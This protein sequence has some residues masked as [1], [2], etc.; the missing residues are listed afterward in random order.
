MDIYAVATPRNWC[1]LIDG[2][3]Y[4]YSKCTIP[5]VGQAIK[6]LL[7]TFCESQ[8][9]AGHLFGGDKMGPRW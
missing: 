6:W 5:K 9:S 3:T 1:Y 7:Q 8:D 2:G 4:C